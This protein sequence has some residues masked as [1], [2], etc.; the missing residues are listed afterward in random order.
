LR[1]SLLV[2][3]DDGRLALA[4]E[5]DDGAGV[6]WTSPV[7]F[8]RGAIDCVALCS[9]ANAIGESDDASLFFSLSDVRIA[10]IDGAIRAT[11]TAQPE[12]AALMRSGALGDRLL[13]ALSLPRR[14][15]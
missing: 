15:G 3:F 11:T 5:H 12:Y 8:S 6:A 14:S 13:T 4:I 1:L 2:D 7:P 9:G 10:A